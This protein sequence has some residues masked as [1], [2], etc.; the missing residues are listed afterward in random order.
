M[1]SQSK[2]ILLL[3]LL[4]AAALPLGCENSKPPD[5]VAT[6]WKK[7]KVEYSVGSPPTVTMKS[8]ETEDQK[9]LDDI[10]DALKIKSKQALTL[11]P[12]MRTNR[13]VITLADGNDVIMHIYDEEQLSYHNPANRQQSYSILADKGFVEKLRNVIQTATG[14]KIHFYTRCKN[15]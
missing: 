11:V 5:P 14:E 6:S 4:T 3:V 2:R 9:L 12:T 8:W 15:K 1:P 13:I 10:H 7:L